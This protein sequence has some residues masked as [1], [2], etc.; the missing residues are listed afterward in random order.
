MAQWHDE[1]V[2]DRVEFEV[3]LLK[4]P[5]GVIEKSDVS[6]SPTTGSSHAHS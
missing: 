1:D 2:P 3:W 4:G 5:V 6:A